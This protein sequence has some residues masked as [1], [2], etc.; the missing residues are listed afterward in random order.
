MNEDIEYNHRTS[1]IF[2][3]AF[4]EHSIAMPWFLSSSK[5]FRVGGCSDAFLQNGGLPEEQTGLVQVSSTA[6]AKPGCGHEPT[7]RN[8]AQHC[9]SR[10]CEQQE[11]ET[12]ERERGLVGPSSVLLLML[13]VRL[14]LF[15]CL[16]PQIFLHI[17]RDKE[18]KG[19]KIHILQSRN[20]CFS[21]VV[22]LAQ[23]HDTG[24][25]LCHSLSCARSLCLSPDLKLTLIIMRSIAIPL[26]LAAGS[27]LKLQP[28]RRAAL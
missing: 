27:I 23:S 9:L 18:E 15:V 4:H 26:P 22:L 11:K 2:L 24:L 12:R 1:C 6:P 20:Q 25:S 3:P 17:V 10:L 19:S 21:R 14:A 8:H 13:R 5:Y 16:S 7:A 28:D